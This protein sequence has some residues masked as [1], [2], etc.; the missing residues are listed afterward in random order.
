M[1]KKTKI[2]VGT[3]T[4]VIGFG[5]L[6]GTGTS[7]A[8]TSNQNKINQKII[9]NNNQNVANDIDA[10][11]GEVYYENKPSYK[12]EFNNIDER[13]EELKKRNE[14]DKSSELLKINE[15]ITIVDRDANNIKNI[16]IDVTKNNNKETTKYIYYKNN[17]SDDNSQ[18]NQ[19]NETLKETKEHN[20]DSEGSAEQSNLHLGENSKT[21]NTQTKS[22]D[23]ISSIVATKNQKNTKDSAINEKTAN[24]VNGNNSGNKVN[25]ETLKKEENKLSI[26]EEKEIKS[27]PGAFSTKENLDN[28]QNKSNSLTSDKKEELNSYNGHS[29]ISKKV[30]DNQKES[31]TIKPKIPIN[32][33][34]NS[35]NLSNDNQEEIRKRHS[36]PAY[37]LEQSLLKKI[38]N[39]E[40]INKGINPGLLL[41]TEKN[42]NPNLKKIDEAKRNQYKSENKVDKKSRTGV[43]E[44]EKTITGKVKTET[45]L[46]TKQRDNTTT[47]KFNQKSVIKNTTEKKEIPIIRFN[48]VNAVE[49]NNDLYKLLDYEHYF[50]GDTT[51]ITFSLDE[52]E[53]GIVKIIRQAISSFNEF[54]PLMNYIKTDVKYS[55][56]DEKK[57]VIINVN[58]YF[59]Q[60]NIE[61]EMRYYDQFVI[62]LN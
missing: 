14:S 49:Q 27:S 15:Q 50:S 8:L 34:Q 26:E 2:L 43:E 24:N 59:D 19:T 29:T 41:S 30:S 40:S 6:V 31:N 36:I 16:D 54:K 20:D 38:D 37:K 25:A 61:N 4:G 23:K 9:E 1:T 28:S 21:E 17:K 35:T 60:Y 3:F 7:I 44:K 32:P 57:T 52:F 58:W 48:L 11:K 22:K 55:F 13:I 42:E 53:S 46:T 12:N 45:H 33:L 18:L 5:A 62:E 47:K 39:G 51:N 10:T 56:G